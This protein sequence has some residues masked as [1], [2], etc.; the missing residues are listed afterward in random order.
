MKTEMKRISNGSVTYYDE[1]GLNKAHYP[2]T[3][4]IEALEK[5]KAMIDAYG[6]YDLIKNEGLSN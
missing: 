3:K 1:A 2:A 5:T 6:G 4:T